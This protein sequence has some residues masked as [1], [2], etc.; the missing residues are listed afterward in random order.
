MF[1]LFPDTLISI[2]LF[3]HANQAMNV[4]KWAGLVEHKIWSTAIYIIYSIRIRLFS[5]YV[6][7]FGNALA[8]VQWPNADCLLCNA[9]FFLSR[10]FSTLEFFFFTFEHCVNFQLLYSGSLK[11]LQKEIF[12]LFLRWIIFQTISEW[13]EEN[14]IR[15]LYSYHVHFWGI[16]FISYFFCF[17]SWHSKHTF[18]FS[19][20]LFTL[21]FLFPKKIQTKLTKNKKEKKRRTQNKK[22]ILFI[23]IFF[24]RAQIHKI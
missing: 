5:W 22:R 1:A 6:R 10:I 7:C 9:L 13:K 8:A 17:I 15:I 21:I 16:L 19:T 4:Q 11:Q 23:L 20:L 18:F 2:D 12:A 14:K 3:N 24:T